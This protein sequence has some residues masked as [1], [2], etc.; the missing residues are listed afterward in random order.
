MIE[1]AA[2]GLRRPYPWKLLIAMILAVGVPLSLA[3]AVYGIPEWRWVVGVGIGVGSVLAVARLAAQSAGRKN[4]AFEPAAR[5]DQAWI[6]LRVIHS[7][8]W[9]TVV[10]TGETPLRVPGTADGVA[11]GMTVEVLEGANSLRVLALGP[12]SPPDPILEIP[13][14]H[15]D[16]VSA[17]FDPLSSRSGRTIRLDVRALHELPRG[18]YDLR[19]RWDLRP[20]AGEGLWTPPVPLELGVVPFIAR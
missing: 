1:P 3:I 16:F 11:A 17:A 14:T 18:R 13:R 5:T 9:V 2:D 12:P 6:Y 20:F 4:T 15:Y 8:M 19:I 10:N 7:T